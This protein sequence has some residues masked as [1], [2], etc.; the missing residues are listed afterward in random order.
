[1]SF[2]QWKKDTGI[3]DEM[4]PQTSRYLIQRSHN[5]WGSESQNWKCHRA[6]WRHPDFSEKIQTEVVRARHTIIWTG[7]DCPTGNS[8]RRETTRQTEKTMGRQHQS[9]DRHWMEYHSTESWELRGVE[10][11][12]CIIYSGAPTV[13]QTT[14]WMIV[15]QQL[16][17]LLP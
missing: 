6:V 16:I 4:L 3:G 5:Q 10:E 12:G 9:V 15:K 1:M 14:G 7:Q 11:A 13:S 2:F 17:P 8:T